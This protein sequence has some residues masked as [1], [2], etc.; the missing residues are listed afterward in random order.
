MAKHGKRYE[1]ARSAI[2]REHAY[3]PVEVGFD[4]VKKLD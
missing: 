2:D 4:N 1:A 3:S